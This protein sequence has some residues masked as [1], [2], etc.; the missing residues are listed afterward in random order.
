MTAINVITQ[1]SRVAIL[2]DT[3]G[4]GSDG[5]VQCFFAK[6]VAIPHLRAAVATRGSS[7]A[8]TLYAT[9]L[10]AMFQTFDDM[11]AD[12]K[13]LEAIY[14]GAFH[15]LSRS[16]ETE[17][18]L[19]VS[20]W[21]ERL[22]R[23]VSIATA[24][25]DRHG[26]EPW[27]IQQC[28]PIMAA[29]T[30]P[31]DMLIA[32]GFDLDRIGPETFD[33]VRHGVMLMQAQRRLTLYPTTG[34]DTEPCCLVGGQAVLT[35][36]RADGVS[37]RVIHRWPDRIGERMSPNETFAAAPAA[38]LNRQQRRALERQNRS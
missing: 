25:S 34:A 7:L 33:P 11:I 13:A 31:E 10:G 16:G 35:E 15:Q 28:E 27:S 5:V 14:D 30:V 3:A 19:F 23:P 38:P 24:S 18:D 2:T 29:P 32:A 1:R 37:Q 6:C 4:Y 20:G 36:I 8:G 22:N 21:S 9:S 17:I 26:F 12:G